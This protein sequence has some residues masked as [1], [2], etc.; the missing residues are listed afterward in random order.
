MLRDVWGKRGRQGAR[1]QGR[2]DSRSRCFDVIY[3]TVCIYVNVASSLSTSSICVICESFVAWLGLHAW[4]HM[5]ILKIIH[6]DSDHDVYLFGF[7]FY[8]I[9]LYGIAV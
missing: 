8:F 2:N 4:W 1:R 7:P 5:R 3:D 9:L 6:P